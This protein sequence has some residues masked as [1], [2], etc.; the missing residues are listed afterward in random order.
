MKHIGIVGVTAEGAA[1]CYSQ[2][3]RT[4]AEKIGGNKHPEISI[5]NRSF[6]EILAAQ[7]ERSWNRVAGYLLESIRKLEQMGAE[8]IIIPA[9]SVHYALPVVRQKSPLPV[10][11]IVEEAADE[12]MRKTYRRV[13]VLGV[14]L[15][16]SGGLYS[17]PLKDRAIEY[18]LPPVTDQEHMNRIIYD[19]IVPKGTASEKSME[20]LLRVLEKLKNDDCD[21]AI[22]ACTELPIV[23]TEKNSPLPIVDSTKILALKALEEALSE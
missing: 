13:A 12:C 22:L 9:N 5:H 14:G 17:D 21:A 6:H 10:L 11:S 18:V 1:Y 2:I 16:M 15:T 3:C 19:E 8:F 23:I 4:A 7:E 20:K